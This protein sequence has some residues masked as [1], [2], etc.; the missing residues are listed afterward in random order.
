[1]RIGVIGAGHIGAT[2]AQRLVDEGHEVAISNSRGREA[3]E[4]IADAI[5]ATAATVE[6][7]AEF[8]EIV[9]E[10]IPLKEYETLPAEPLKGKIVVDAANYYPGRDGT[11]D[12]I[13]NGTAST[14][15]IQ[16]HLPDSKVVKAFNTIQWT[17]IRDRHKPRGENDRLAVPV[18]ADDEDAKRTVFGLVDQV[19]FDPVDGGTLHESKRQEP[20]TPVYGLVTDAQGAREAIASAA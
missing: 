15:L 8:G 2:V 12:E 9:F 10:A 1:M 18:A 17:N 5:G 19:G 16:R 4:P 11:F 14:E 13:E 7:A 20:D 6:E 3:V